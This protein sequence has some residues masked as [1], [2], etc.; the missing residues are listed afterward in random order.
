MLRLRGLAESELRALLDAQSRAVPTYPEIGGTRAIELPAGY[1]HD[2]Y[3]VSL[4]ADAF[5]RAKRALREWRAHVDAGVSVYPRSAPIE[6]D[7]AR[8]FL[9]KVDATEDEDTVKTATADLLHDMKTALVSAR[10]MVTVD[11]VDALAQAMATEN[12]M[13]KEAAREMIDNN[14]G[15][16]FT[17]K[18]LRAVRNEWTQH[19]EEHPEELT[20][21]PEQMMRAIEANA[22]HLGGDETSNVDPDS[23]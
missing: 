8:D 17:G 21:F 12:G 14:Q 18:T 19:I 20:K 3:D 2:H 23:R 13:S 7:A 16:G 15:R 5:E 10:R 22:L 11:S 1:T 6:P 9:S 4:G